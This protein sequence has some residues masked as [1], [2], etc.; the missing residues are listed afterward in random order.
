MTYIIEY[1]HAAL[2]SND[3]RSKTILHSRQSFEIYW[4]RIFWRLCRVGS[5]AE[6]Y[7]GRLRWVEGIPEDIVIPVLTWGLQWQA[8][9]LAVVSSHT[10]APTVGIRK[11]VSMG[12]FQYVSEHVVRVYERE[13][14]T[15]ELFVECIHHIDQL[16]VEN[17]DSIVYLTDARHSVV[18][19]PG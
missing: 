10:T 3:P 17:L 13:H 4:V 15:G 1:G 19:V 12:V 9:D 7:I 14:C 6:D 11:S 16:V 8:R 5:F 18:A 2:L